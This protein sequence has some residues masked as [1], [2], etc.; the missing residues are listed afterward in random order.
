M[1]IFKISGKRVE[2]IKPTG[3][4]GSFKEKQLQN[5][6]EENSAEI[7]DM[8]FIKTEHPTSHGGRI[9]TLAIDREYSACRKQ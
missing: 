7:F 2:R 5:L 8:T 3:F 1:P 9:D 6:V 4:S